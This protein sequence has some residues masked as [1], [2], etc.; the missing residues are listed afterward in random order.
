[1]TDIKNNLTEELDKLIEYLPRG[2]A[3][4]V[5][6]RLRNEYKP[7]TVRN[8]AKGHNFNRDILLELIKYAKEEQARIK[9]ALDA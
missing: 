4:T 7:G 2:Y 1:M 5:A 9:S 3:N 8:V 6:E